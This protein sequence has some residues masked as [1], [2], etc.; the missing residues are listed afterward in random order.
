MSFRPALFE[1]MGAAFARSFGNV[2]CVFT[3]DG[4]ERASVRGILRQ[5]RDI[6]LGDELAQPVEGTTHLL[7]VASSEVPGLVSQRD[8]VTIFATDSTG[9]RIDNGIPFDVKNHEDDGR[10]MLKIY[11]TGDI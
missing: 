9:K 1:R 10:A 7:S 6:D 3:I 2:D 5:W 8:S 4:A 11:L